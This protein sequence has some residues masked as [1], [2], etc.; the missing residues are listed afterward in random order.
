[1]IECFGKRLGGLSFL[2]KKIACL[3]A[4]RLLG[5]WSFVHR[6]R[7]PTGARFVD[8]DDREVRRRF[9]S[10]RVGLRLER[11]EQLGVRL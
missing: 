7:R 6:L 10:R 8:V 1:V 9:G 5:R 4:W 3:P 2:D 11:F